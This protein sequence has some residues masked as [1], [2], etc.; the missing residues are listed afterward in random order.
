MVA[1]NTKRETQ[2]ALSSVVF[3]GGKRRD[4]GMRRNTCYNKLLIYFDENDVIY[5]YI[6]LVCF[7]FLLIMFFVFLACVCFYYVVTSDNK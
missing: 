6:I 5:V 2:R 4:H 3:P 7:V 1:K